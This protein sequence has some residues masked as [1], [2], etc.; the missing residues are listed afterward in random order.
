MDELVDKITPIPGVVAI[1]LFGSAARA[2]ADEYSDIDVLIL[3]RDRSSLWHGWDTVF[4]E[5]ASMKLNVHAIPE[6]VEELRRANSIFLK[7]LEKYG[8]VL[9]A[10]SPF[11]AVIGSP[12]RRPFSIVSYDLSNLSYREKMRVVYQL[13]EGGGKGGLVGRSGGMKLA[14]GCVLVPRDEGLR[15][16]SFLES[17]KA[18]IL[19]ID[20]LLDDFK[21]NKARVQD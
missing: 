8:K 15:L 18:K 12:L 4:G 1:I 14:A 2:Q 3:F 7:E 19:K 9:Y 17:S 13:Y 21:P 5:T 10:R 16:V 11:E 20:V 6:T